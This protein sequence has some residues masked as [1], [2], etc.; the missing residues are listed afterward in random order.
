MDKY[1][2]ESKGTTYQTQIQLI[3]NTRII[4][5]RLKDPDKKRKIY[6]CSVRPIQDNQ[7]NYFLYIEK[8]SWWKFSTLFKYI[9]RRGFIIIWCWCIYVGTSQIFLSPWPYNMLQIWDFPST[10]NLTCGACDEEYPQIRRNECFDGVIKELIVVR[11][12]GFCTLLTSN[13]KKY[14]FNVHTY[15]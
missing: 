6:T 7:L 8:L 15:C 14:L 2:V 12:R 5:K 10:S 9:L 1:G 3:E 13:Q 11:L 4:L